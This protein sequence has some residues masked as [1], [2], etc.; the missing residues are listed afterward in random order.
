MGASHHYHFHIDHHG[1][2]GDTDAADNSHKLDMVLEQL[3][4]IKQ[5]LLQVSQAI[6]DLQATDVSLGQKMDAAST[7]MAD[8]SS[9]LT[10]LATKLQAA[11]AAND[12]AAI[13]AVIDDLNTHGGNLSTASDAL[14]QALA[15]ARGNATP[16][17]PATV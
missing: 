9:T 1:D 16:T 6:T 13:Q 5:R 4:H 8:A 14:T 2:H 10:D 15:T 11:L 7:V 12:P 17:E 3:H